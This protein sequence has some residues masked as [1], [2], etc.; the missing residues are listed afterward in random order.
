MIS[1][2]F[3]LR[4][5]YA[6]TDR[7][8]YVYYGRYAEYLEVARTELIRSLGMSYKKIEAQGIIMPVSEYKI[9]YRKPAFYDDVLT[10]RSAIR[11]MPVMRMPIESSIYNEKNE[12]VAE[13]TVTLAFVDK[14]RM[15]PV[16]APAFFTELIAGKWQI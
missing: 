10:I 8:D 16:A 11:E 2:E 3:T 15:R 5:R 12:L 13:G 14:L 6:D 4:V 7:M 9:R 1:H